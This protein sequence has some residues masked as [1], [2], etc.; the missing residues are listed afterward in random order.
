MGGSLQGADVDRGREQQ[1]LSSTDM[2]ATGCDRISHQT[3]GHTSR[4][5]SL[6]LIKTAHTL[7]TKHTSKFRAHFK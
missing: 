2:K 1:P 6:S 5:L 4:H 3:A 7:R